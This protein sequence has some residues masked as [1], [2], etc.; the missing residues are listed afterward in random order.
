MGGYSWNGGSAVTQ[1]FADGLLSK[2]IDLDPELIDD[3]HPG[4]FGFNDLTFRGSRT[5]PF[6]TKGGRGRLL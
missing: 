4:S 6:H 5:C 1:F 3:A 2:T